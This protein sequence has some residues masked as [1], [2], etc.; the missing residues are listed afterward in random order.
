MKNGV[1]DCLCVIHG[2]MSVLQIRAGQ[3]SFTSNLLPLTA[4]IYYVMIIV[5]GGFTKKYFFFFFLKQVLLKI[6]QF[7]GKHQC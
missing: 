3:R 1:S 6:V 7:T 2:G 4:H 5:T